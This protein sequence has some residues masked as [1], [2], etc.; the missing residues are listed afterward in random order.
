MY[1][2]TLILC[3]MSSRGGKHVWSMRLSLAL[4]VSLFQ[5]CLVIV[6]WYHR[7]YAVQDEKSEKLVVFRT[8]CNDA[9]SNGAKECFLIQG[10]E[11]GCNNYKKIAWDLIT[12][13]EFY[14]SPSTLDL[15]Q[16]ICKQLSQSFETQVSRKARNYITHPHWHRV[17]CRDLRFPHSDQAGG[18]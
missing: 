4:P 12:S 13:L 7:I 11:R 6:C 18:K 3:G 2:Q 15:C 14:Y 5:L 9:M 10:C 16:L 17:R 8:W 1:I